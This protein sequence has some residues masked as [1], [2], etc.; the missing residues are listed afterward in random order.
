MTILSAIFCCFNKS[1]C[2]GVAMD[3][4]VS[5]ASPIVKREFGYIVSYEE[6]LQRLETMAQRLEDTKASVQHSAAEAERKGEKMEDIVENWVKN[7][8]DAV[9]EANK[10][11]EIDGNAEADVVWGYFPIC[12]QEAS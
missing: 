7:A 4:I 11:I 10:L 9:A 5:V 8:N 1:K 3:T 6:N 12:G 2:N